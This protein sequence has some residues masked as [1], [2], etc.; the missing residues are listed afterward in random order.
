MPKSETVQ[1][2]LVRNCGGRIVSIK[3]GGFTDTGK[4]IIELLLRTNFPG[5]RIFNAKEKELDLETG[6]VGLFSEVKN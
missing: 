6:F 4:K 1:T 3:A 5:S 2:T